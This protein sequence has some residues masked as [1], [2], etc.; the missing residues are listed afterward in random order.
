MGEIQW[1]EERTDSSGN[2]YTQYHY[3][4]RYNTDSDGYGTCGPWRLRDTLGLCW[5]LFVMLVALAV[6]A[7]PFVAFYWIGSG[8][9][10]WF[11]SLQNRPQTQVVSQVQQRQAL[12]QQTV[13]QPPVQPPPMTPPPPTS[14]TES[15]SFQVLNTYNGVPTVEKSELRKAGTEWVEVQRGRAVFHFREAGRT[16][17]HLWLVDDNRHMELR[18]PIQGGVSEIRYTGGSWRR[19]NEMQ[20]QQKAAFR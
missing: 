15:Y 6:T 20:P 14:Q 3:E 10:S 12:A 1:S 17:E 13:Y 18:I 4:P 2:K 8:I 16:V 11:Q 9:V 5:W 7:L 19:W